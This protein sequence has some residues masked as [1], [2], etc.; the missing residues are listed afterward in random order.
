VVPRELRA[1]GWSSDQGPL[2][3]GEVEVQV[4][5]VAG[6]AVWWP[7]IVA[8]CSEGAVRRRMPRS[9]GPDYAAHLTA[10]T[11]ADQHLHHHTRHNPVLG[12]SRFM[13]SSA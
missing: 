7:I 10:S 4:D 8:S 9:Y 2:F 1:R 13:P 12:I 3:V 6:L 5:P 11:P